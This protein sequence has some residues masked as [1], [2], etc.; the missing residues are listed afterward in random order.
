MELSY[1][2]EVVKEFG[3]NEVGEDALLL[4]TLEAMKKYS[5]TPGALDWEEERAFRRVINGMSKMFF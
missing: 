5:E 3:R 4:E 2:L 1:A